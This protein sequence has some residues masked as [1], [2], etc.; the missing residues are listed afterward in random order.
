MVSLRST[1]TEKELLTNFDAHI[2]SLA[3]KNDMPKE[4]A[5]TRLREQY[6]GYHFHPKGTGVYNPFSLLNCLDEC[7]FRDYWFETGTPTYLVQIL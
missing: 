7:E 1:I 4:K 6:D 2:E 5:I 3:E